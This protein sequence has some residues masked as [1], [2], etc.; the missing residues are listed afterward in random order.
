MISALSIRRPSIQRY[1][2]TV[3]C[4]TMKNVTK[5]LRSTNRCFSA[6]T[7]MPPRLRSNPS[8]GLKFSPFGEHYRLSDGRQ[9][10]KFM[11]NR[12]LALRHIEC[13]ITLISRPRPIRR[14]RRDPA[15]PGKLSGEWPFI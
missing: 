13:L 5:K 3:F 12:E 11:S 15:R 7:V 9:F 2:L 10:K 4:R 6:A 8:N 1:C 14:L